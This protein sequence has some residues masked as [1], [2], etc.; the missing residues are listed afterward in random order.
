MKEEILKRDLKTKEVYHFVDDDERIDQLSREVFKN[1]DLE[2]HYPRGFEG[3]QKYK[4]I[5]KVSFIGFGGKIPVGMI[6]SPF[7]GYGFTKTLA[8]V[9]RYFDKNFEFREIIIEKGG[10]TKIDST[11]KLLYLNELS[12]KKMNGAF[13]A[14]FAKN[15]AEI[16]VVLTGLLHDLFPKQI[17]KHNVK[18]IKN[19]LSLSL[20]TWGN[21]IDEFSE[22]D[23]KAIMELFESLSSTTDFLSLE[24][25][26]STKEIVDIRLIESALSEFEDLFSQNKMV[27]A[28]EKKWQKYLRNN[29]WIFS[30]IFAQ[31]VIL[32]QDEAYTGGKSIDNKNGKYTDIL[33]KSSL[34][35][36]VAFFEI[37]T[38]LT[39]LLEDR[40]YRGNDVFSTTREL[41]GSINQV[42]NQRDNF[43]KSYATLKLNS[44][45]EFESIGSTCYVLAGSLGALNRKQRYAFELFRNN[46]RDVEIVTFDEIK[47]KIETLN[48][49]I[50]GHFLG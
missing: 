10:C 29:A 6:K 5:K 46:N 36:N 14:V 34:S 33:I 41:G 8:P 48:S 15:K 1:R 20:A 30:S 25:L 32:F 4:T 40:A 9:A 27:T 19:A 7:Y 21:A 50:R 13:T 47:K 37:K 44:E 23:K 22:Q 45:Q 43:Q 38:H 39:K 31:P 12:L 42:L 3:G 28:L 24:S 18:Y 49:I 17:E 35:E 16:E 26:K 2:V 11:S